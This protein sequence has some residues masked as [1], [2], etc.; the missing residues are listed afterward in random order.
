MGVGME[1]MERLLS[2]L[3]FGELAFIIVSLIVCA[4][5]FY[6]IYLIISVQGM[7]DKDREKI[8]FGPKGQGR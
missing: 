7:S 8:G 4:A 5:L 2:N 3:T 1:A 6:A